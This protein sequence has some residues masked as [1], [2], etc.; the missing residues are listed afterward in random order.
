[1]H[2]KFFMLILFNFFQYPNF[3]LGTIHSHSSCYQVCLNYQYH[4]DNILFIYTQ[5]SFEHFMQM[6]ILIFYSICL[7]IQ[8]ICIYNIYT[9]ILYILYMICMPSMYA[10]FKMSQI[11][12]KQKNIHKISVIFRLF[13]N[14]LRTNLNKQCKVVYLIR[15]IIK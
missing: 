4:F 5:V 12:I 13:T 8:Y 10:F 14:L 15:I 11:K 1:M 3:F 7:R 6:T 9:Y 2:S